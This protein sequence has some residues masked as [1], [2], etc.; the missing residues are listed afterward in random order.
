[1]WKKLKQFFWQSRGVWI[2]TPT[3]ASLVIILRLMGVLQGWEWDLFDFYMKSRPP[4][5][6]DNRIAIIGIDENDLNH[7]NESI[8][9]DAVL[10]ELLEKIKSQKPRAIGLD[11]YRD[12]P[13]P[14]G[15]NSLVNIFKSTPNLVGIQKVAGEMGR[16][17]VAPP[18]VLKDK[19]Q[20]GANDLIFDADNQVRRGLIS[21][22]TTSRETIY[23]FS[24]HLA[25][26]YLEKENISP[27]ILEGTDNWKLGKTVFYPLNPNE[28]SYIRTDAGGYQVLI[29]YR[30]GDRTFETVSMTDILENKVPPNWGRDRVILIGKVGESFKDLFFTPYSSGL[31]GLPE[32]IAGV[33]IH[34]NLTSQLISAALEGRPLFKSWPDP[35]EYLWIIFWSGVGATLSW[36][37]RYAEGV[38]YLS[39]KRWGSIIG[40]GGVLGVSTYLAFLNGWWLPVVPPFLSLAGSTMAIT[41]YVA[42][43]AGEIRKTFGRYLTDQVVANLLENPAGL[44]MGGERKKITILTSDLRGFTAISERLQPEEVVKILNF[45]LGHMAEI[46]TTYQGTIDEFMGD[47]ILVLFGA[48]TSQEDEAQRAVACGVAMQLAMKPINEQMK[49]WDL[50]KLEMGI[51]INTGEVVVGNIGSEKRTK[52]GIVGSQVNLT[53]RIESYTLGGQILISESTLAEAGSMIIIESEKKVKPKGVQEPISIYEVGGIQGDYNLFL[54]KDNEIFLSV[55]QDIPLQYSILSGKDIK[56]RVYQGNLVQLSDNGGMIHCNHND[57]E[58]FPC[59]MTNIKINL[60]ISSEFSI[61]NEDVY[62]KVLEKSSHNSGFYIRFT[63]KPPEVSKQLEL[64]YQ[65]LQSN[66]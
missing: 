13:V 1:M 66:Q 29:N 6:K 8:I 26:H 9:T 54:P 35:L 62:A 61:I 5:T 53:Y 28:G 12:L 51:G 42:R 7:L 4:E 63:A 31:I 40:A 56:E 24:L 43:T 44:K 46:I 18:L 34:A 17:T 27:E 59:G 38:K 50:P 65:A 41:A 15:H 33:E 55:T 14:P 45:Y 32:P 58:G 60:F 39:G 22:D 19:G 49:Q 21:L 64:I 10:A 47:G 16:E 52:Y 37:F 11:I 36:Q 57:P 25:L 48:P 3:V 2:G 30:G 23:S 20:V